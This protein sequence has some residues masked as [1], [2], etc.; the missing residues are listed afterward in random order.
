MLNKTKF[1]FIRVFLM[2][3]IWYNSLRHTYAIDEQL[4]VLFSFLMLLHSKK[5]Q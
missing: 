2:F 3:W 1:N 5:K 4:E